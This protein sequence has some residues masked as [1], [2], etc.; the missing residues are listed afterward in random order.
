[1]SLRWPKGGILPDSYGLSLT[2]FCKEP[3]NF[4]DGL[5]LDPT[6]GD[7]GVRKAT[8]GEVPQ[9]FAKVQEKEKNVPISAFVTGFSRNVLLNVADG[10][11]VGDKLVVGADGKFKKDTTDASHIVVLKVNAAKNQAEVLI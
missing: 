9:L 7:Y 10:V 3:V 6:V 8:D 1:M 11:A 5:I 2:V 4:G